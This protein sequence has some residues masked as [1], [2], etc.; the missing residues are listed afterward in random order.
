MMSE[1]SKQQLRRFPKHEVVSFAAQ[2]ERSSPLLSNENE[3]DRVYAS[4][5][6]RRRDVSSSRL[7]HV[8]TLYV[9]VRDNVAGRF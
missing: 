1:M 9:Y 8:Q 5:T 7:L 3:N 2:T 4:G 6:V